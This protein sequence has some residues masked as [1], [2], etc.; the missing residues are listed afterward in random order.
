MQLF[1]FDKDQNDVSSLFRN[2]TL[3]LSG[4]V[5]AIKTSAESH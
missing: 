4:W 5:P 1:S 3:D 2:C